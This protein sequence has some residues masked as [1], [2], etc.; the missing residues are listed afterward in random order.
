M[1]S[2]SYPMVT[3]LAAT[4]V[5][6]AV[7]PKGPT[8]TYHVKKRDTL[9]DIAKRELGDPFRWP[10]IYALNRSKVKNPNLIYP[11]TVLTMPVRSVPKPPAPKPPAP[12]PPAPKPPA[13]KP[14]AP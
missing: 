7:A 6:P 1:I 12:K 13:P 5:K 8:W 9:W 2:S 14:P 3:A 11:G 4:S 10:E